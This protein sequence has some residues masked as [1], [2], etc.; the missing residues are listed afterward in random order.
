MI[1]GAWKYVMDGDGPTESFAISS[2]SRSESARRYPSRATLF[3]SPPTKIT[4]PQ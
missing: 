4:S 2:A 1:G 3:G